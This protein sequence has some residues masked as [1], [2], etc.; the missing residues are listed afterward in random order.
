VHPDFEEK[1][2]REEND[3]GSEVV[4]LPS[5]SQTASLRKVRQIKSGRAS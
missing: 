2:M 1:L 5:A 4:G 3:P